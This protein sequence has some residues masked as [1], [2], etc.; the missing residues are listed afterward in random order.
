MKKAMIIFNPSSGKEEAETYKERALTVLDALG[1]KIVEKETEKKDDATIFAKQACEEKIEFLVAMGG[2]G[3]INEVINGLAN[4]PYRPVFSVIPLGTVN[5]FARAIGIPLEPDIAIEALKMS[6]TELVDIAQ[7]GNK[8]FGNIVAIGEIASSVANTS[9]EKKTKLGSL[10]YLL[11]GAKVVIS[12]EEVGFT[13]QHDHGTWK[14]TA[15]LI[16]IG[17]TNSVGGFEKMITNAEIND[18]LLHVYIFKKSGIASI[19]RMGTKI[20]LGTLKED[21]GVEVI[22][23][24]NVY[25]ESDRPLFCNVD[26]DEGICTPF[27]MKVLP[28]HLEMLIPKNS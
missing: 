1:Y 25:M 5:D 27:E 16:L 17:L 10:A 23:T 7:I 2:D 11:E 22:T 6:N 13:I 3:T 28:K 14:G 19:V 9:I 12:N 24:K 26:G 8:Y 15:I 21:D 4:Q 20:L 18:G